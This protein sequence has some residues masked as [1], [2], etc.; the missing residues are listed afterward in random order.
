[1]SM[2]KFVVATVAIIA[3]YSP[4]IAFECVWAWI[5]EDLYIFGS[6]R[7]RIATL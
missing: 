7:Y 3:V 4:K 5:G 2:D 6:V 1:M